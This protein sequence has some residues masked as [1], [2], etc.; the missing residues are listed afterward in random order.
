MGNQGG[1]LI[2]DAPGNLIGGTVPEAGNLIA[3]SRGGPDVFGEGIGVDISGPDASGNVVQGNTIGPTLPQGSGIATNVNLGNAGDGVRITDAPGNVIGGAAPG[4]DNLITANGGNGV[5]IRQAAMGNQ[6]LGNEIGTDP[7]G[8]VTPGNVGDGVLIDESPGNTIGGTSAGMGNLIAA[9]GGNG[10]QIFGPGATGNMVQGNRIGFFVV[11]ANQP[12]GNVMDGVLINEAPGNLIGGTAQGAGNVISNNRGAGIVI[13][14]SGA[15]SNLIQGNKIGTDAAGGSDSRQGNQQEGVVLDGAS[16]NVVGGTTSAA[17]TGAGNIIT[18]NRL[19]GIR[20]TGG[21]TPASSN[22][23]QGNL[24]GL[25]ASG[26]STGGNGLHGLFLDHASGNLIGGAQT[27]AGNVISANL[28]AGIL[29]NVGDT[30]Q[31]QGNFIGTDASGT[32]AVGNT[33]DGVSLTD[34]SGNTI[35]GTV[36]VARNLIAGNLNGVTISGTRAT[37]N[38][39]LGDLIGTDATGSKPLRNARDG[40][41]VDAARNTIG[42]TAPGARNVIAGNGLNGIDLTANAS[43]IL[44]QGNYIGVDATGSSLLGNA[45]NGVLSNGPDV[46]IGGPTAAARNIISGNGASGIQ[47]SGVSATRDVVQGNYIGLDAGGTV[48]LGNIASGVFIDGAPENVIGGNVISGNGTSGVLI[49]GLDSR[50][51]QVL[52]NLIGTDAT[53]TLARGNGQDGLLILDAPGN[54]VGGSVVG[55]GNTIAGNLAVGVEIRNSNATGN[56]VLGNLIGTDISGLRALGNIRG[57]VLIVNAPDNQI[58]GSMTGQERNIISGNGSTGIEIQGGSA[59]SNVVAGNDIGTD[60]NG[61]ASLGNGGDGVLSN[62]SGTTIGGTAAGARNVVA[63]NEGNG[64]TIAL[65][66]SFNLVQAN[67]IGIDLTGSPGK[68]NQLDGILVEGASNNAIGGNVIAGNGLNGIEIRFAT[69]TGNTVAGNLIGTDPSGARVVAN[70]GDG[71]NITVSPGNTIGGST[72]GQRNII[73]GNNA[74]GITI[75]SVNPGVPGQFSAVVIGNS[76]G[77]DVTGNLPLGNS[78]DGILVANSSGVLIGGPINAMRNIVAGNDG[79]GGA[80]PERNERGRDGQ[81]HRHQR[82]RQHCAAERGR[83]HHQLWYCQCDRWADAHSG[84]RCGQPHLG[85]YQRGDRDL[86]SEHEAKPGAG[87]PHRHRSRGRHHPEQHRRGHPDRRGRQHDRRRV[88]HVAQRHLGKHVGRHLPLRSGHNWQSGPG[89]LHRHESR[90]D[91]GDRCPS[92]PESASPTPPESG[93]VS[94]RRTLQSDRRPDQRR[95]RRRARCAEPDFGQCRRG[96]D[97]RRHRPRERDWRQLPRHRR[98][99]SEGSG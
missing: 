17:G 65:N 64:I 60:V 28:A 82:S 47:I 84:P 14:G 8:Q 58:G 89:Q 34:A 90:R 85:Q 48:D 56:A 53:G 79:A 51:N 18:D 3:A 12:M 39:I 5:E 93:R 96:R 35:G 10:V 20:I 50:G 25:D 16:G 6:V 83:G 71:V 15:M 75:S 45:S 46:T 61:T 27:G 2:R 43:K 36:T 94:Q 41:F 40:V 44:V 19:S 54:T 38:L 37:D 26:G 88:G 23:V 92:A 29:I 86:R 77:T 42:G 63:N 59:S 21:T 31:V 95:D 57:G 69:A 91:P 4:A 70:G 97:R 62:A 32:R 66:A 81:F 9:N 68:G 30:N 24:I 72:P 98:D 74:H 1:V 49:S 78:Q 33:S 55:A 73:A 13:S 99:R 52:G 76:I 7:T 11:A 22:T 87:Q 80:T 67:F